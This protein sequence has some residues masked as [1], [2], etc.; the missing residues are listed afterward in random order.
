MSP[1]RSYLTALVCAVCLLA[2]CKS[3]LYTNLSE[4]E[5]NE[6]VAALLDAGIPATKER[7]G[8]DMVAVTVDEQRFAEAMAV[9][10]RRGL[11]S[12]TYQSLGD[13][14]EKEGIVSSP[15]E[16]RARFIYAMSQEL[17]RTIAEIDG[18][19]SARVHVVLPE[20]DMLGR[21][22]K[23]SSASVFMRHDPNVPVDGFTGQIKLLIANSLEGLV[24]DNVTVVSVPAAQTNEQTY[25]PTEFAQALGIWVHPASKQRLW[26]LVATIGGVAAFVGVGLGFGVSYARSTTPRGPAAVDPL[27][28]M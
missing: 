22:L 24:Y 15:V 28:Q 4:R 2:G 13:I 17:A 6:M 9:L 26:V 3:E 18:V 27:D 10:N 23:P 11:P 25:L 14:F 20:T 19:L 7:S 5:A 12:A 1:K 16:E 21:D 8:A